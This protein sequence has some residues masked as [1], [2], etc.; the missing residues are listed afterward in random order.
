MV[1][2]L[3]I[4]PTPS[5]SIVTDTEP[6][7]VYISLRESK[8]VDTMQQETRMGNNYR[9]NINNAL[10]WSLKFCYFLS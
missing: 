10:I 1:N 8:E 5:K 9:A 6:R 3:S 2:I 4:S 7:T